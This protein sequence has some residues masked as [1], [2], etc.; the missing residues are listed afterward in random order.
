ELHE[1]SVVVSLAGWSRE[2]LQRLVAAGIPFVDLTADFAAL[3]DAERRALFQERTLDQGAAGHYS[4]A[5]NQF[6][7]RAVASALTRLGLIPADA[8]Q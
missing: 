1:P 2:L 3:P 4:P 7:A 5:G 8:C 6:V